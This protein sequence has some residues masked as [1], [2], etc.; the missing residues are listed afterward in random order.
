VTLIKLDDRARQYREL[1]AETRAIADVMVHENA[2]KGMLEAA[3]VWDRLAEIVERQLNK[4]VGSTPP[5][6]RPH[7]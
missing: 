2:R 5:S 4:A 7:I 6:R 1:A 3:S